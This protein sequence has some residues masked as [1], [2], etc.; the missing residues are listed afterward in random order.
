[1]MLFTFLNSIFESYTTFTKNYLSYK[2]CAPLSKQ[3]LTPLYPKPLKQLGCRLEGKE[4]K[5]IEANCNPGISLGFNVM[6]FM[7][8]WFS[9]LILQQENRE[10]L[11]PFIA[12]TDLSNSMVRDF[13]M[14]IL[15]KK[16]LKL[17]FIV[18]EDSSISNH[19]VIF[20]RNL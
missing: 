2:K 16:V 19:S 6:L 14:M 10:G 8:L 15:R 7:Y 20:R 3:L 17:V 11:G 1:M 12:T 13:I 18:K 9:G 5:K 4:H